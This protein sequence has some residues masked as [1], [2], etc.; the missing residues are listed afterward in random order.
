MHNSRPMFLWSLFT[1]QV[2]C[3]FFFA[4]DILL[5]VLGVPESPGNESDVLETGVT[6]CL[7]LGTAF[8]GWELRQLFRREERM[9]RQ[10]D[11]ASGAFADMLQREFDAWGLTEAEQSV[12]LLG[13][14]GYS[15]SEIARLRETKEGTIKAQNASVYRK[16]GVT[17][18]LQLLSHF[19]EDL[20]DDALIASATSKA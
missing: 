5:D 10:I 8:T 11:V 6:I 19:V 13:I 14:K 7:V 20:M 18:R 2:V 16:A 1:L 4:G 3:T 12:A 15:I 17:G 9:R